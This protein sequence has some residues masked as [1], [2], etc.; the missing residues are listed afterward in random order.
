M[1]KHGNSEDLQ[2]REMARTSPG[3]SSGE[4]QYPTTPVR[5]A[6]RAYWGTINCIVYENIA[7]RTHRGMGGI[8]RRV[9]HPRARQ[10]CR[11]TSLEHG[12][13]GE[14]PHVLHMRHRV[15]LAAGQYVGLE[16]KGLP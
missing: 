15:L 9:I 8:H 1:W 7:Y 16:Q 14:L 3:R 12:Y 6:V 2:R 13:F 11:D 10:R 4:E 5:R